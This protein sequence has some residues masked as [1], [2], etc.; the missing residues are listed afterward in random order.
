MVEGGWRAVL[1]L[2]MTMLHD[3]ECVSGCLY[4]SFLRLSFQQCG[5][6]CAGLRWVTVDEFDVRYCTSDGC[7]LRLLAHGYSFHVLGGV[8]IPGILLIAHDLIAFIT[9]NSGIRVSRFMIV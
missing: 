7:C 6:S 3:R 2:V 4:L 8:C 1:A 5:V 9:A